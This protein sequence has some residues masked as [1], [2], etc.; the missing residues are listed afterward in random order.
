MQRSRWEL[1]DDQADARGLWIDYWHDRDDADKW[2]L[3]EHY[4]A[5]AQRTG[6]AR[7]ANTGQMDH[8]LDQ[9]DL[10]QE[11]MLVLAELV[12]TYDPF[13]YPGVPFCK[14]A[15]PR[16]AKR[17]ISIQRDDDFVGRFGRKAGC[18]TAMMSI[19]GCKQIF[20]APTPDADEHIYVEQ[21]LSQLDPLNAKF[22]RL[23]WVDC[24][25]LEQVAEA[26]GMS[27]AWCYFRQMVV[28]PQLVRA[29]GREELA[30]QRPCRRTGPRLPHRRAA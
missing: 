14:F 20:V 23:R 13:Q 25:P 15:A 28:M 19:E 9:H 26:M 27:V 30:T 16:L 29:M 10:S 6:W 12:E 7:A 18:T 1:L 3:V 11:L 4:R 24:L 8:V 22:V 2:V 17:V 5:L 21:L